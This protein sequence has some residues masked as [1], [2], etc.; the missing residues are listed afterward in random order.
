LDQH[1][2]ET[3]E[4]RHLDHE[5]AKTPDGAD[6][7]ILVEFHGL[8]GYPGAVVLIALLNFLH[9]GL[10]GGHVAYL[11]DLFQGQRHRQQP[12]YEGEDD[13]GQAHLIPE[14][15]VQ[16][17]QGVDHGPDDYLIPEETENFQRNPFL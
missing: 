16:D 11:P 9:L 6:P 12:H 15:D 17:Q 8:L 2:E 14:N 5:G 10:Q 13:D 7:G 4:D 1:P 3:D